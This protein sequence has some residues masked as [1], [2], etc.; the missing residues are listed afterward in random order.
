MLTSDEQ[1]GGGGQGEESKHFLK[2]FFIHSTISA[3][4]HAYDFHAKTLI[5][6]AAR[7]KVTFIRTFTCSNVMNR[8]FKFTHKLAFCIIMP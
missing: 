3:D 7:V 4:F 5:V 6:N 2:Y 8:E 1:D